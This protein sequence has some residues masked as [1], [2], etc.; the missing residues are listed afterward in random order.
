MTLF[1]KENIK[2][3]IVLFLIVF[4]SSNLLL[5]NFSGL[6]DGRSLPRRKEYAGDCKF[7]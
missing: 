3:I 4:I 7:E 5:S 6:T 1:I 2:W